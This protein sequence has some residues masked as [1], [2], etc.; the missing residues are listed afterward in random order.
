VEQ[1][2]LPENLIVLGAVTC[3]FLGA[4]LLALALR[5][6]AK[7]ADERMEEEEARR[8]WEELGRVEI[9]TTKEARQ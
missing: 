5:K 1:W 6:I 3:A 2:T 9:D 4:L 8:M 7:R